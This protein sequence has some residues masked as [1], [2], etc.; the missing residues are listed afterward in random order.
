LAAN[1]PVSSKAVKLV[2]NHVRKLISLNE[3]RLD[4]TESNKFVLMEIKED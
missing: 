2:F 3:E 1:C 4:V